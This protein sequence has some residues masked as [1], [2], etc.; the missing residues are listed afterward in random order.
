MKLIHRKLIFNIIIH[1][2]GPLAEPNN[3]IVLIGSDQ[4]TIYNNLYIRK[5]IHHKII[6]N[7]IIY[8]LYPLA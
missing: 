5:L 6:I 4:T 7:I 2:F 8:I 1:I 3:G